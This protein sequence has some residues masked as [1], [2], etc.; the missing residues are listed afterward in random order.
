MTSSH[1][2]V[3]LRSVISEKVDIVR[4]IFPPEQETRL[5]QEFFQTR[6]D[7]FFVE[8]GANDPENWSQTLH[9]EKL[10]WRGVLIEPQP[11]LAEK[12]RQRRRAKVYGLACSSPKNAGTTMVLQLAGIYSSLEKD[13]NISTVQAEKVIKVPVSTLDSVLGDAEAPVPIDFIS[14]DVEG[15]EIDVLEGFGLARWRPRLLLIEDL[16]MN[17]RLHRYLNARGYRWVRRTGLNSW[18]V[19]Q[20]SEMQPGVFGRTQFFRKYYLGLPFRHA[21]EASRRIRTRRRKRRNHG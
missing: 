18:Y 21:R 8:V 5:V 6:G 7:G 13:L 15:H 3:P 12:L 11:D 19:P 17:L 9:L 2:P 1:V 4:A 14:I 20:D 10:G 16:A